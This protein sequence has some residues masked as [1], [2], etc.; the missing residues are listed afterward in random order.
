MIAANENGKRHTI[1]F[2]YTTPAASAP[3]VGDY[4]ELCKVPAG[5]RILGGKLVV[6][7]LSS[8]A[9]VAGADVG[10]DGADTRYLAAG[11]LDAAATVNFGDS[12]ALNYGEVLTAEK[13]LRAKVTGEAW[14]VSKKVYGEV[15][16]ILP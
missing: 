9:G 15:S 2:T 5:A 6:E 11:N 3:A 14:A 1:T 16:V 7:A 8:G 13:T 12:I 10:Y 4:V